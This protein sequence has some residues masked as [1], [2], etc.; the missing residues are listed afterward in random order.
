VETD[1]DTVVGAAVWRVHLEVFE[2]PLD[3]LLTLVQRQSLDIT[4][5][6]LAQVTDQYL[7]YMRALEAIEPSALAAF[8]E[9]AATLL[10]LKSRALL[11]R[12]PDPDPV[13]E[14]DAEA[15]AERLRAYRRVRAAA[16]LLGERERAGLHAYPR[17]APPPD[18]PPR[19]DN[20]DVSLA[21]L[22]AAF[23]S[24]L[25]EAAVA[26]A[27]ELPVVKPNR[28]RLSERLGA[29]RE[30]LVTRGSVSFREVLLGDRPTREYIV[31]SF[32][33][34][35]ELLRRRMIRAA[36]SDLFGDI[37]LELRPDAENQAGWADLEATFLDD[38][39][40]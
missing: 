5:V 11:P 40:S 30:L 6:A 17:A 37:V 15:L 4:T 39:A 38:P 22:A 12:P 19:L 32:L 10:L 25:T 24:A 8:C 23:E 20:L 27:P 18:L 28:V 29:I 1:V 35:L 14:A 2:G 34:V 16:E 36:Q 26:E 9:V 7:R 13:E 33:A 3:L 21:D 31:V